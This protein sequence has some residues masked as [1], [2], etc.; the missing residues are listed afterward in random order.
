MISPILAVLTSAV[1]MAP[2][3]SVIPEW[4]D[5]YGDMRL[6][7]ESTADQAN[8]V[9]R[10]RGRMRFRAGA[11]FQISDDLKA[12]VRV[13]SA[14]GVANNPHWDMGGSNGTD[15]LSGS[16]MVIDRLLEEVRIGGAVGA[17]VTGK[18]SL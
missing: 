4:I 6:R 18:S 5:F 12:E 10:T 9:D 2:Q 11:K 15:T 16:D 8:G 13:S 1:P 7:L 3:P 14:S 17:G